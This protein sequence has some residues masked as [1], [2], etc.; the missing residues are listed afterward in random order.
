MTTTT[1]DVMHTS[2]QFSDSTAQKQEDAKRIFARAEKRKLAW[3]TGTEAGMGAS[4]DLRAALAKESKAAGYKFF[5]KSDVWIAVNKEIITPN[6]WADGFIKTL[7]ANT[8]SQRFSD[9]GLLWAEFLWK[10]VGSVSIGV[11]HYMTH[12]RKPSDEYFGAN[13][14]LTRAIGQWG[15]VHGAGRRLCFF[16]GDTNIPDRSDDVFRGQP[17]TTLADE[18]KQW[19]N[20]GHGSIDVIASYDQD[21][22]VKG[23][24]WRALDDKEFPLHTDHFA[25]EGGFEVRTLDK[26]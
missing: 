19:E 15:K 12:G 17:F 3:V 4:G 22:R 9:R 24:Y 11:S 7:D 10:P 13:T 26:A 18:L 2:M 14:K 1:V 16:Q 21:S 20:T 25:V 8:G 6:S 5:V 23:K